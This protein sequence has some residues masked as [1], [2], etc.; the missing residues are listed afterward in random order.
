MCRGGARDII[1]RIALPPPEHPWGAGPFRAGIEVGLVRAAQTGDAAARAKLME[2]AAPSIR[3]MSRC[4]SGGHTADRELIE[5]G[6]L[7]VLRALERYDAG[8]G[9]P[10]WAYASWWVRH[11]MRT[12]RSALV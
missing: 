10:F 7:G 6:S 4:Y 1:G 11:A 3:S 12:E 5:A 8:L 9:T 2:I